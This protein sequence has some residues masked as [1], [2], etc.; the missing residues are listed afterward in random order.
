LYEPTD[1]DLAKCKFSGVKLHNAA[2]MIP[3][4]DRLVQTFSAYCKT[5]LEVILYG[6]LVQKGTATSTEDKYGYRSRGYQEG[7]Y[8]IFGLG[9]AGFKPYE[10]G[11][12]ENTFKNLREKGFS[13]VVSGLEHTCDLIVLMNSELH[14]VLLEHNIRNTIDHYQVSLIEALNRYEKSLITGS[15]EGIVINFGTEIL[16]WKG[17]DESYPDIFMKE[18]EKTLSEHDLAKSCGSIFR[19]ATESRNYW[20]KLKQEKATLFLLEKAYKSALTKMK[21]LED[22][23]QDGMLGSKELNNFQ[24]ALEMEMRRDSHCDTH[25]QELL[26]AF[27]QQKLKC[28]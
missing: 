5:K 27:V 22:R 14:K 13:C 8:Y 21:N 24:E 20:R 19:V 17:L 26:P 23:K 6:E 12:I 18:I 9:L 2:T 11:D 16:K 4:L 7:G 10:A 3:K 25:F 1:N 15:L 28:I